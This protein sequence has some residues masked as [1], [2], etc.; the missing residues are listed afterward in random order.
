MIIFQQSF[1]TIHILKA[2]EKKNITS[3]QFLYIKV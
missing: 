1:K 3:K 2:I